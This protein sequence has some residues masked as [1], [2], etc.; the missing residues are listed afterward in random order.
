MAGEGK[1]RFPISFLSGKSGRKKLQNLCSSKN[2]SEKKSQLIFAESILY[3]RLKQRERLIG[4]CDTF[5]YRI[6]KTRSLEKEHMKRKKTT[7]QGIS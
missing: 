2:H 4:M 5:Q 1:Q 6:L 7:E 3:G